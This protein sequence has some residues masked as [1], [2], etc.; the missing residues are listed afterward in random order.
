MFAIGVGSN[1]EET[2]SLMWCSDIGSAYN[3]PSC[4]IPE[5]GK[6]SED[7]VESKS[8]VS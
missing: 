8:K 4:V 5:G 2:R 7:L 6:V 3:H 1:N